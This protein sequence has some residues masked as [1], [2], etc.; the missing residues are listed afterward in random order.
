MES[1]TALQTAMW[2]G[3]GVVHGYAGQHET[4]KDLPL[5]L[6][7]EICAIPMALPGFPES[8]N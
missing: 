3:R 1:D 8:L 4:E 7:A 2:L 6:C 5:W